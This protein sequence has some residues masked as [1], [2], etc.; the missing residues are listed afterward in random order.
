MLIKIGN[1]LINPAEIASITPAQKNGL[2]DYAQGT[3]IFVTF[4]HAGYILIDATMAE[5]KA[6]LIDV[7]ELVDLVMSPEPD[8]HPSRS[9]RSRRLKNSTSWSLKDI[10][11][12]LVTRTG[13]STL[14][15]ADQSM[16][17]PTGTIPALTS[18]V[19]CVF[20]GD[21]ISS[22]SRPRIPPRSAYC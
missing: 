19:P 17:A 6:A 2:A 12:W 22:E 3:Q 13:D 8:G 7:G 9:W 10:T 16:T 11:G 20:T 5:A 15:E 18:Q 21:L 4:R 1:S 14:F